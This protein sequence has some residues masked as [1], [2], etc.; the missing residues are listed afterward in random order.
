M[1]QQV[2]TE[3]QEPRVYEQP[4]VD[5]YGTLTEVTAG[6]AGGSLDGLFGANGGWSFR[7]S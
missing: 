1:E 6:P 4:T 7:P 2:K 3:P 5:D